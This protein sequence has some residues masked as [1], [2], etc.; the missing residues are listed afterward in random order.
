LTEEYSMRIPVGYL[1]VVALGLSACAGEGTGG[2]TTFG[3][4][5][6]P[7][8]V[9]QHR[10][11]T[12]DVEVYWNCTAPGAGIQR[13]EGVV[14]NTKSGAVRFM[15]LELDA[16]DAQGRYGAS[17]K[18]ALP[19]IKLFPNQLAPFALQLSPGADAQRLDLFY[20]YERDPAAGDSLQVR[21]FARD[22]CSP[23]QH[24]V[25]Q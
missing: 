23:A 7:P 17:A 5:P 2:T 18:T 4:G 19:V 10:V 6:Y 22:V 8:D 15:E 9:Y 11:S 12:N 24:R 3:S 20:N 14:R 1:A 25:R 16:V 21:S 13:V